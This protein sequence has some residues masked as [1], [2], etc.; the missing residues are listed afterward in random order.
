MLLF[1]TRLIKCSAKGNLQTLS[2][3]AFPLYHT[4]SELP[5]NF[6]RIRQ[7][8][9]FAEGRWVFQGANGHIEQKCVQKTFAQGPKKLR[10]PG[11]SDLINADFWFDE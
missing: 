7:F 5:V 2:T 8:L 4:F 11:S 10:T 1:I 6:Q 9:R 3:F